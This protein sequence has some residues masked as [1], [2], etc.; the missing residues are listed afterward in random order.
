[1]YIHAP[2][3]GL[4]GET[5][6]FPIAIEIL[7]S[8]FK[9]L[10]RLK[11]YPNMLLSAC[12]EENK[13]NT[14]KNSWKSLLER[15]LNFSHHNTNITN[16]IDPKSVRY[17]L[18]F[19]FKIWWHKNLF[20]DTL[21]RSEHG[22][23]LRVYR[24]FKNIFH[25]EEYLDTIKNRKYMSTFA[26]FRISCHK[27]N[28]ET[29]RYL[30]KKER[31]PPHLR[32]CQTCKKCEDEKHFIMYCSTY[33]KQRE[34]FLNEINTI[35]PTCKNLSNDELFLYFMGNIDAKVLNIFT[36]YL[37]NIYSI[38]LASGNIASS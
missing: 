26:Q 5:G 38:R 7:S 16:T 22:N 14:G 36:K 18:Q 17:S 30:A 31:L 28:I 6:R 10:K 21:S 15:I 29:G 20:D 27:L 32:L 33:D 23:K 9:Y 8:C 35:A 4:Y 3:L 24:Q 34:L 19:R 25:K 37:Y 2:N 12:F 1:M 13:I 11:T